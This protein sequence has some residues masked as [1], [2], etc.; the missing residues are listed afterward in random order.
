LS[1]V[2]EERQYFI[3]GTYHSELLVTSWMQD[4]AKEFIHPL[5]ARRC[6]HEPINSN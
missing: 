4:I 6:R 2:E 1:A 3:E 5:K